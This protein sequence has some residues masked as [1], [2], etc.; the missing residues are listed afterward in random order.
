MPSLRST[1]HGSLFAVLAAAVLLTSTASAADKDKDKAKAAAAAA[2]AGEKPFQEWS[3]ITKDAERVPGFFT[4]WKK[5]DN[6]YLEIAKDQTSKPF[7]SI[8]SFARGIGKKVQPGFP[9]AF[10]GHARAS[11]AT[12]HYRLSMGRSVGHWRRDAVAWMQETQRDRPGH[13]SPQNQG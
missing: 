9:V 7:L 4:L 5:R 10:G 13:F 6:L 2:G 8:V 12:P 11:P 3:K 1:L